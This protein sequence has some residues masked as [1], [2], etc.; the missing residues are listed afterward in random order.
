MKT[1]RRSLISLF[2]SL[3]LGATYPVYGQTDTKPSEQ[4]HAK[5]VKPKEIALILLH[6]KWGG[7]PAPLSQRFLQAGFHV[8]SPEMPWSGNRAYSATYA[9]SLKDIHNIVEDLKRMGFKKI[10]VGGQSFGANG[11]LAYAATYNDI[12][13]ALLL[14]PGHNPDIGLN[15][16]PRKVEAAKDLIKLGAPETL[17]S[18]TDYNDGNRTR[19]FQIRADVFVSF[20]D[21]DGL[22]NM[23]LSAGKVT[24]SI[25]V[26][27]VMGNGD[28]VTTKGS[29][30]FFDQLPKN[31]KSQY[32]VSSA[33]HREVPAASFDLALKWIVQLAND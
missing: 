23:R 13:G 33:K 30:Y 25:P 9:S 26:L 5:T 4:H 2:L 6:G 27:A 31:P 14:A 32:L 21:G 16:Q 18:F 17:V 7:P 12:D 15:W 28:Y 1:S 8:V 29:W 22:A 11:A 20:F 10:I 24:K 3:A 19:D